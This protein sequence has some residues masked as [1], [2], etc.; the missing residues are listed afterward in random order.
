MYSDKDEMKEGCS[1]CG[2]QGVVG[3]SVAETKQSGKIQERID[4]VLDGRN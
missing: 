2:I 3:S 1:S 4:N